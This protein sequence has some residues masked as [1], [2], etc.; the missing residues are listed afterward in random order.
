MSE[1]SRVAVPEVMYEE[2]ET[3]EENTEPQNNVKEND[4]KESVGNIEIVENK[5]DKVEKQDR[6]P[7]RLRNETAYLDDYVCDE[8]L[9]GDHYLA[10]ISSCCIDY[11]YKVANVPTTYKEAISSHES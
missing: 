10:D 8:D 7:R 1:L 2:V 11:C 9:S 5:D 3:K 6:Y 4:S